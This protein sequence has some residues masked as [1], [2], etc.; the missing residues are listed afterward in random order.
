MKQGAFNKSISS[1]RDLLEKRLGV[2]DQRVMK[3]QMEVLT[4]NQFKLLEIKST[5][6]MIRAVRSDVLEGVPGLSAEGLLIE[7]KG[8]IHARIM[9]IPDAD[10]M[11]EEL[12]G[13]SKPNSPFYG[14]GRQYTDIGFE[15][16]L[17]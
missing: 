16:F 11:P 13:K 9:L 4:N 7:P 8:K 1:E 10:I 15:I 5:D 6:C 17:L 14:I 2:V 12:A 3:P